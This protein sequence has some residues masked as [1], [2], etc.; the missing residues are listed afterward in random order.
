MR[1]DLSVP[2]HD[3]NELPSAAHR[4]R[5]QQLLAVEKQVAV[6]GGT[7]RIVRL[8]HARLF[9]AESE[10]VNADCQELEREIERAA[11]K[12]WHEDQHHMFVSEGAN[13]FLLK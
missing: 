8:T 7:T 10:Y 9:G 3:V 2:V 11:E 12:Y 13:N 1:K 4:A 6:S 5:L